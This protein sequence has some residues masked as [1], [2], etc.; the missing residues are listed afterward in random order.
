MVEL[1]ELFHLVAQRLPRLILLLDGVDESSDPESLAASVGSILHG[2]KAKAILFSR[3][4]IAILQRNAG[5]LLRVIDMTPNTVDSDI[6]RLLKTRLEQFEEGWLPEN[7]STP[8][9]ISHLAQSAKGMI[10]WARLMLDFLT[11]LHDADARAEAIM[12]LTQ[13]EDLV[14]MYLRILRLISG[15]SLIERNMVKRVI[16]YLSFAHSHLSAKALWE[17]VIA[18]DKPSASPGTQ[19]RYSPD[20]E[21]LEWF[22]SSIL[23][24]CASLVERRGDGYAFI[25]QSVLEFFWAGVDQS[26]PGFELDQA[27]SQ[28]LDPPPIRHQQIVVDCLT[29]LAKRLHS[30]PLSGDSRVKIESQRVEDCLPFAAYA[31]VKWPIHLQLAAEALTTT[32]QSALSYPLAQSYRNLFEALLMFTANKLAVMTWIELDYTVSHGFEHLDGIQD[33]Y[34]AVESLI[35]DLPLL[36]QLRDNA[37]T[38]HSFFTNMKD[39]EFQWGSKLRARPNTIWI[40]VTVWFESRFLQKTAAV[41]VYSMKPSSPNSQGLATEPLVVVSKESSDKRFNAVLSIWPTR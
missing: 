7:Y 17:V 28:F 12:T 30:G 9:A 19:I 37:T 5:G 40:D 3:P 38:V 16:L 20:T 11:Q 36:H 35:R 21:A 29:Y 23:I 32:S 13:H 39:L 6:R 31:A 26:N 18:C 25:H 10:L 14:S 4:N 22:H 8:W 1:I 33:R 41:E 34:T 15:K 2:T 24:R 27:V